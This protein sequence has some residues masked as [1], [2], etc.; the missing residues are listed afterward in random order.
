MTKEA[1]GGHS[2]HIN[3]WNVNS[4]DPADKSLTFNLNAAM[5]GGGVKVGTKTQLTAT[6]NADTELAFPFAFQDDTD[7]IKMFKDD[8]TPSDFETPMS[9]LADGSYTEKLD[10]QGALTGIDV[11]LAFKIMG[12]IQPTSPGINPVND[13]PAKITVAVSA[14]G[15]QAQ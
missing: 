9:S 1:D 14:S 7:G 15:I 11:K 4:G 8:A 3:F 12:N 13:W 5:Y 6:M 2:V 10:K